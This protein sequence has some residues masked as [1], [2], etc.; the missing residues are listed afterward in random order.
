MRQQILVVT[1][2][3]L[4]ALAGCGAMDVAPVAEADPDDPSGE[5]VGSD[6]GTP[7][8]DPP[9]ED[10]SAGDAPKRPLG[11]ETMH[12]RNDRSDTSHVTIYLVESPAERFTVTR[13]DGR[14][15]TVEVAAAGYLDDVVSEEVVGIAPAASVA[16]KR[17][18]VG[19][20]A[21]ATVDLPAGRGEATLVYVV[22]GAGPSSSVEGAGRLACADGTLGTVT[23][24]L[25]DGGV[26]ASGQCA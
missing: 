18:A 8:D 5:S 9:V 14:T 21:A 3:A 13:A 1:L 16:S 23:L 15:E 7:S 24:Q 17:Y 12:L 2:A 22:T 25:T 19:A 10:V 6:A 4:V 26:S 11:P 20:G